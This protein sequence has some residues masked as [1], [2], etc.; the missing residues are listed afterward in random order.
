MARKTGSTS[1]IRVPLSELVKQLES[2]PNIPVML[3]K[4]WVAA[5]NKT[6]STQIQEDTVAETVE[7]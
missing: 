5:T 2:Y 1:T 4:S 3:S 7:A 6:L